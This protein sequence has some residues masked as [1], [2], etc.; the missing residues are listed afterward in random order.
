M[1]SKTVARRK[2]TRDCRF[3]LLPTY[4]VHHAAGSYP[5]VYPQLGS[6]PDTG[7]LFYTRED[8]QEILQA[9]ADNHVQVVPEFD[10]P[11]HANAA[12]VANRARSV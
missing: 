9:A 11:G 5:G 10:L 6:G 12:I 2:H 8:Y 7:K 4:R 1:Q 3:H